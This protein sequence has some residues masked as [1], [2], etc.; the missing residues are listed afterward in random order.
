[1]ALGFSDDTI[2]FL[3][4]SNMNIGKC[5]S[6]VALFY[7]APGMN[8]NLQKSMWIDVNGSDLSALAIRKKWHHFADRA[9]IP[10]SER[11]K[12]SDGWLRAFRNRLQ[13][14]PTSG[15]KTTS[16]QR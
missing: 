4:A 11:L 3:E 5:M 10:E 14:K 15:L 12:L 2:L 6:Y 13:I 1:M 16:S 9:G 7:T 8:L